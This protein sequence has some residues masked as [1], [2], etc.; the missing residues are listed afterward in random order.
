MSLTQLDF[1][2]QLSTPSLLPKLQQPSH[3]LGG[4]HL[5]A[6]IWLGGAAAGLLA[7]FILDME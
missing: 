3:E 7:R 5:T 2:M 6:N 1:H 4:T